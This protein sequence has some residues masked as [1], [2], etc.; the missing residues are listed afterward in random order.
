MLLCALTLSGLAGVT[1]Q[2]LW[3]RALKIFLGGSETL[4]SMVVVLVFLL[5]LGLGAQ[6]TSGLARRTRDPIVALA[7]V[8]IS[9]GGINLLVALLLGLDL[10]ET[11]SAVQRAALS[12]GLPIRAVY[13][14]SA[15]AILMLPTLA[16]GSTIPL[17]SEASQR[18][19]HASDSRLLP[20]LLFVNTAGAAIGA[21]SASAWM[22][23][24]LG[25]RSSLLCAVGCNVAAGLLLVALGRADRAEPRPAT[26][27]SVRAIGREEGLGALLGLLALGYEMVLF[28]LLSLAHEPL[29]TT[30]ATGLSAYLLAWAA[31]AALAPRLVRV[32]G[33]VFFGSVS[34]ALL[35]AMVPWLYHYEVTSGAFILPVAVALYV[36]P[37]VVF[38]ALY[39]VLLSQVSV[40]WGRDVGRYTALNTLGSGLG[41]V[42]FTLVGHEMPVS[43]TL[44]VIAA[45]MLAV[46]AISR[47]GRAIEVLPAA[48]ALGIS[49]A[50][51]V[52]LGLSTPYTESAGYRT[53]WGRDGV[54]EVTDEGNVW[55]DGLWHTKLTDGRDH[56]G[57][58]YTWVMAFAAV[59]AHPSAHPASGLVVGAGVGISSTSLAGI[60]GMKVT[61]YEINHT[62][63]RVLRDY[64]D[65]TRGSLHDPQIRWLWQD[66][67][68]GLALDETQYDILLSAPLH[69]RQAGS[70]LLLSVEYLRLA[71][72]RLA[73]GGVLAVYSNEGSPAQTAMIQRTIAE[74]FPYRATWYDGTV[75]VA[76]DHPVT[77]TQERLAERLSFS[78]R[79]YR[80]ARALDEELASEGGLWGLY[81]G[82]EHTKA[83]ADTPIR[84]D[85]PLL[86]YPELAERRVRVLE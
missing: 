70:S 12:F 26:T 50:V 86:E 40:D 6:I 47:G 68:V 25:Q 10:S 52:Y 54:V 37:C 56:I 32:S 20:W 15:A 4:S 35:V 65:G 79:L 51:L 80:E 16:M 3:Q 17:A 24:Y 18:Q 67:R 76:A 38:G 69:L 39:G 5:G 14:I 58:P 1:N 85:H 84:D 59:M 13:A 62:L 82:V 23:P 31:G 34:G 42:L 48:S 61:G 63:L 36:L 33:A 29:P 44:W 28:R 11:V 81:D 78:D 9:L 71:K 19:L 7:L 27:A 83:V 55:I 43:Y 8:E 22:L 75:T 41:I 73:P 53:Y 60:D 2:V 74:V 77:L 72:S 64:P 30:F 46:A 57:H 49:A 21:Y 66:A 45:A